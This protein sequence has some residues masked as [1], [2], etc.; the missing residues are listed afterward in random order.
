M[1]PDTQPE[2]P[3]LLGIG[4]RTAFQQNKAFGWFQKNYDAYGIHRKSLP[5]TNSSI[6][7][8]TFTIVMGTWC[9]DSRREVPRFYKI[10][11]AL[12]VIDEQITLI[13]VDRSKQTPNGDEIGLDIH[14]VPTF[15]VYRNGDE[16]GRIVESPWTT[17]EDDLELILKGTAPQPRYEN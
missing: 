1:T 16:I 17:L 7:N 6:K 13:N 5:K 8:L 14:Y 9:P 3:M 15:I 12:G 2:P 11:D 10:L 4:D